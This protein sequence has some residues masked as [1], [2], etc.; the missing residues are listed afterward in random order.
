AAGQWPPRSDVA[1]A[2]WRNLDDQP[3]VESLL[4]LLAQLDERINK[5]IHA[6]RG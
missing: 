4:R 2:A 1:V 3:G 6:A 5:G